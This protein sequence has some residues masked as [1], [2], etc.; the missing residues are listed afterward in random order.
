MVELGRKHFEKNDALSDT[1]NALRWV[2]LEIRNCI[3]K[4]SW[5]LI[6]T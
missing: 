1:H 6:L 2:T 4:E 5:T 3:N